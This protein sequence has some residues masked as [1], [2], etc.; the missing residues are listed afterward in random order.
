MI[1]QEKVKP[2]Y[3]AVSVYNRE[4]DRGDINNGPELADA[5]YSLNSTF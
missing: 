1:S 4:W 3:N 2:C 5:D